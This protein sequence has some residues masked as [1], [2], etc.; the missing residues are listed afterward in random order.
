MIGEN[1][2]G[3]NEMA[4]SV[5]A[6]ASDLVMPDLMKI[7]G[8]SGWLR[9]AGIAAGARLPMASHLF[10]EMTVHLMSATPTAL[11]LEVMDLADPVLQVPLRIEAGM[12]FPSTAPGSGLEWDAKAVERMRVA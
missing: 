7:G 9:A 12:A 4:R 5:A 2:F 8:V 1:W 11:R 6:G 3:T 10:Q